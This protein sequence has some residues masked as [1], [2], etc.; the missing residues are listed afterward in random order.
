M[1]DTLLFRL[2]RAD[3]EAVEGSRANSTYAIGPFASRRGYGLG[4][5]SFFPWRQ[6]Q[7]RCKH[8][9]HAFPFIVAPKARVFMPLGRQEKRFPGRLVPFVRRR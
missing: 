3:A 2:R 1:A 7:N 6:K 9:V 4:P 8:N 5:F